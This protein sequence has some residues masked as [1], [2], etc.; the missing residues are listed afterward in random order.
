MTIMRKFWIRQD[1]TANCQSLTLVQMIF[2]A[3][4]M[5]IDVEGI[6]ICLVFKKEFYSDWLGNEI[7]LENY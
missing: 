5:F 2:F 6:Y 4:A 3:S 7:E 1:G